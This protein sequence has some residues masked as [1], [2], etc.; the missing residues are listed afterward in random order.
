MSLLLDPMVIV[1]DGSVHIALGWR[2]AGGLTWETLVQKV[3]TAIQP[4]RLLNGPSSPPPHP[5][6][7]ALFVPTV[8]TTQHSSE[9]AMEVQPAH[10]YSTPGM[11]QPPGQHP[12]HGP[13]T[14]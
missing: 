12:S 3:V 11:D 13:A 9:A 8:R 1:K 4:E 7:E 5:R 10:L 14:I 2:Q 6:C